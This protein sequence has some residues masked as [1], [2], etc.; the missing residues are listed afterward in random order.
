M[1]NVKKKKTKYIFFMCQKE[2]K[3]KSVINLQFLHRNE[4]LAT[5]A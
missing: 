3:K 1:G 2:K 4:G 5:R